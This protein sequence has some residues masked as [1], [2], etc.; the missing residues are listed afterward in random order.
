MIKDIFE[1]FK[2]EQ[3]DSIS[4]TKAGLLFGNS[5]F[6]DG[7]MRIMGRRISSHKGELP[8]KSLRYLAA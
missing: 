6:A 2:L 8:I 7:L 5:T 1:E 3:R 4:A